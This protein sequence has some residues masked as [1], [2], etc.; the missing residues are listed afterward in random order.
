M[1]KPKRQS[2]LFDNDVRVTPLEQK[3]IKSIRIKENESKEYLTATN[4]VVIVTKKCRHVQG[5][6]AEKL[7]YCQVNDL[8]KIIEPLQ[9]IGVK[10]Y[11][12]RN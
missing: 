1:K 9:S 12:K 11:L 7:T 2:S 4:R 6:G 10:N 8:G 5:C 3:E